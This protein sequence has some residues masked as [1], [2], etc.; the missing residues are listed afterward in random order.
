MG[1]MKMMGM[2][3]PTGRKMQPKQG[4]TKTGIIASP[5]TKAPITGMKK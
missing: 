4:M 2:K 1:G 3:A 5:G